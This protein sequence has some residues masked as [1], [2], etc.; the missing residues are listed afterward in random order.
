MYSH[1]E[2]IKY[3]KEFY[4]YIRAEMLTT[5]HKV[6][7]ELRFKIFKNNKGSFSFKGIQKLII[8]EK[9]KV[10]VTKLYCPCYFSKSTESAYLYLQDKMIRLSD[11]TSNNNPVDINIIVKLEDDIDDILNNIKHALQKAWAPN[12]S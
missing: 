2:I 12:F 9:I 1:D 10:V 6:T 5:K 3:G 11:H 4:P 7:P 8:S